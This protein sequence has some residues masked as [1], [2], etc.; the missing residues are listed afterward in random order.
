VVKLQHLIE[1]LRRDPE[2]ADRLEEPV[3]LVLRH[4]LPTT[5]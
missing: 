3:R 2:A 5:P 4:T 1:T